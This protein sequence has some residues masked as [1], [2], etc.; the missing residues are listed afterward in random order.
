MKD[1]IEIERKYIIEKPEMEK[2][3][4]IKGVSVSSI[5]QIYLEAPTGVTRRIRS[6][7]YSDGTRYFETVKRRIDEISA[8]EDER[9][10]SEAEFIEKSKEIKKGSAPIRKE[11]IAFSYNG[12]TLEIDI[13]PEWDKTAIMEIELNSRDEEIKVPDFLKIIREV[14]GEKQYSN[15]SM[16]EKFPP[17]D[18]W[19]KN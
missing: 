12:K 1:F 18:L 5:V 10:I 8:Y 16:S 3:L 13:Y 15:A 19:R 14:S 11:R 4:S 17:E 7:S 9:E 6:R 2:L